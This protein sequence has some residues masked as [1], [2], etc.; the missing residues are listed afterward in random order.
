MERVKY[1]KDEEKI[2]R[3]LE[4]LTNYVISNLSDA[5]D[6]LESL[7]DTVADRLKQEDV[8]INEL[9]KSIHRNIILFITR[10]HPFAKDLRFIQSVDGISRDLE[11]I[12][13]FA[14]DIAELVGLLS[15]QKIDD[16]ISSDVNKA[17]QLA[18][19]MV[20]EVMESFREK[21]VELTKEQFNNEKQ[22]NAS[23][24]TLRNTIVEEM[25][26]TK[27]ELIP[28]YSIYL[29][30]IKYIERIGD[31]VINISKQILFIRGSRN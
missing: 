5:I 30:L 26:K 4:S 18:L 15:G 1:E 31:H 14:V 27:R 3:K 19:D 6:S 20:S 16:V 2:I 28:A 7:D 13:D 25:Q 17:A 21:D 12:G 11:R 10:H 22:V 9:E 29:F 24:E 8:A 23:Y